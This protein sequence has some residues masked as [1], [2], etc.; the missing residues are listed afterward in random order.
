MKVTHSSSVRLVLKETLLGLK[1]LSACATLTGFYIFIAFEP[2]VDLF[3][4]FCIAAA[5][6][7]HV[8][9]PTEICTFD[10]TLDRITVHQLRG[11]KHKI[12]N[13]PISGLNQVTVEERHLW[14]TAFY[15]VRLL[16][17]SGESFPLTHS[18]ST[19]SSMQEGLVQEIQAFLKHQKIKSLT[20]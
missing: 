13:Y 2:P 4:G 15:R 14:G 6:L 16:F 7:I 17:A 19:D 8:L 20:H 5:S 3:G 11:F 10:K 1:V 12:K 9:S 18:V